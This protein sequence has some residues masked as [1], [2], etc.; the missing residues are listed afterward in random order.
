MSDLESNRRMVF[1]N[2]TRLAL[3]DGQIS[4]GE[5]RVLVKLAHAL[6][7]NN[8]EPKMI[9][10]RV[11]EGREPDGGETLN[12][13]EMRHVYEQVLEAMLIH[14][15]R[16]D[17]VLA[18]IAFLRSMFGID[19]AE[20]RAIARSLDRHLEEIV[21]RTFIEEFRMRLNDTAD[22][23]GEIFEKVNILARKEQRR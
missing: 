15:D 9:Y 7:L 1:W 11:V 5:K 16:S 23:M 13:R 2:A 12:E 14:T 8:D 22:R 19:E 20:H 18:Q 17:D 6:R 3:T 21:H 10:D 4:N